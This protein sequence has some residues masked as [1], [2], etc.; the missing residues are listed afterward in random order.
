[1]MGVLIFDTLPGLF[2][3]IATSLVLLLY[4]A[5]RPRIAI[6]GASRAPT[7]LRT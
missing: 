2:I 4:R 5:Y 3:G 6:L 1:M 7:S